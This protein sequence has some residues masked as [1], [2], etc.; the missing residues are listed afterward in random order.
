M[1]QNFDYSRENKKLNQKKAIP[2]SLDGQLFCS[3]ISAYRE[4]R[5]SRNVIKRRLADPNN[6]NCFILTLDSDLDKLKTKPVRGQDKKPRAT[7]KDHG[8][9]IH[10]MGQTRVDYEGPNYNAWKE[11]V[12]INFNF[13]C[14]VTGSTSNLECHHLDSWNWS[15]EGRYDINNGIVITKEIHKLF[16]KKYGNGNN[17]GQHF[18]QFLIN[19]Y[20]I[21]EMPWQ[22]GNHDPS[23]TLQNVKQWR[24]TK[25]EEKQVEFIQLVNSRGHELVSDIYENAKS[26]MSVKCLKHNLIFSVKAT[27]YKKAQIGL[28]CCSK[29]L[30]SVTTTKNNR[31]RKKE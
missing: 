11:G 30:Q 2:L 28:S 16:H 27:Y 15:I 8:N 29:E 25:N 6:L 10:G 24:K 21:I 17:T 23:L 20:N 7:G 4:T 1:N 9:W 26:K 12:L 5:I 22:Y 3:I 14:F 18:E 13:K 19:E 31:L